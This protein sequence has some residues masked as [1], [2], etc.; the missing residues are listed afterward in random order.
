MKTDE[1][2]LLNGDLRPITN[3]IGFFES[4]AKTAANAFL[5]WKD[6]T[7]SRDGRKMQIRRV[8]AQSLSELLRLLLP[9]T[10]R[11]CRWLFVE[12]KSNWCAFLENWWRG[13][14]PS[15]IAP[16]GGD[17][18]RCRSI[19]CTN[20]PYGDSPATILEVNRPSWSE[21]GNTERSICAMKDGS[22]WSFDVFGEPFSFEQTERYQERRT[23]DRFTPEMLDQYLKHFGIAAFDESFYRPSNCAAYLVNIDGPAL[24]NM[25]EYNLEDM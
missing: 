14:D 25:K 1:I 8:E 4:D 15:A 13:T 19:R 10:S 16:L 20:M 5:A 24:P 18:L 22:N 9:L 11:P 2:E 17:R 6:R 12:T 3:T 23:R 7:Y 21:S